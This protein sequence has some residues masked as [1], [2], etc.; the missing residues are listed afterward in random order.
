MSL[1]RLFPWE[2]L[3]STS[4]LG[5]IG[6]G[7]R[8]C[9]DYKPGPLSSRRGASQPQETHKEAGQQKPE[10]S[11]PSRQSEPNSQQNEPLEPWWWKMRNDEWACWCIMTNECMMSD[12]ETIF[13]YVHLYTPMR[14][15]EMTSR[16][17]RR[18]HTA[19]RKQGLSY[20]RCKTGTEA[21][22]QRGRR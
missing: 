14:F 18:L 8:V 12:T 20:L 4:H 6:G 9:S 5:F 10:L 15:I 11:P 7:G 16:D 13:S 3:C 1:T 22:S 19:S 21:Q 17:L 2:I